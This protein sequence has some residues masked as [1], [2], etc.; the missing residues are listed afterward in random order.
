MQWK[1]HT[2]IG[3]PFTCAPGASASS[4]CWL[5]LFAFG[6]T[7]SRRLFLS[8]LDR[9][10]FGGRSRRLLGV[11]GDLARRCGTA[12]SILLAK[13]IGAT[14]AGFTPLFASCTREA[15]AP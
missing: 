11:L 2:S 9:N 5:R 3:A 6:G 8:D 1:P 14:G 13:V 10:L 15:A 7:R 12:A 4:C